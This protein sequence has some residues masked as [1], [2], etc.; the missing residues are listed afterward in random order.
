MQIS[1]GRIQNNAD[2]LNLKF[3]IIN[4][5]QPEIFNVRLLM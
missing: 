3:V 5:Q 1:E 4:L 2:G